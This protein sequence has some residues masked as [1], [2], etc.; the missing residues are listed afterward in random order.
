MIY[1]VKITDLTTEH[2]YVSASNEKHAKWLAQGEFKDRLSKG[3]YDAR[4][5]VIRTDRT[6]EIIDNHN[7]NIT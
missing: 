6:I 7:E 2:I 4:R 5:N 1:K 3:R